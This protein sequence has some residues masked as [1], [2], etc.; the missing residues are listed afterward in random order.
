[1]TAE[2]RSEAEALADALPPPEFVLPGG[3]S[4]SA[5]LRRTEQERDR[6]KSTLVYVEGQLAESEE[7][8]RE[9]EMERDSFKE[10]RDE[11]LDRLNATSDVAERLRAELASA[12]LLLT[13]AL[14]QLLDAREAGAT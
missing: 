10:Q 5:A 4:T 13:E 1:M 12:R 11:Y 2:Y 9:A 8:Y 7:A 14:Q 6:L 3:E